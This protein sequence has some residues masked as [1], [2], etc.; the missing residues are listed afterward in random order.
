MLLFNFMVEHSKSS[1]GLLF[2]ASQSS[3]TRH[4][5]HTTHTVQVKP[6]EEGAAAKLAH[7][8]RGSVMQWALPHGPNTEDL[9]ATMS[10]NSQGSLGPYMR[11]QSQPYQADNLAK[12]VGG[13]LYVKGH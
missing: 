3:V 12:R 8:R 5:H 11:A 4:T 13:Y 6:V 10:A 2:R 7:S 1:P 9:N